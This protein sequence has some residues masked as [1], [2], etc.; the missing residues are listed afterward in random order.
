MRDS[1]RPMNE[2]RHGDD[3][4]GERA[5]DADVE[6]RGLVGMRDLM[7]M[8]APKR[9]GQRKRRTGRKYGRVAITS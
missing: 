5:G 1:I 9:A 6:Q 2:R 3:E 8:N 4:A 7:R